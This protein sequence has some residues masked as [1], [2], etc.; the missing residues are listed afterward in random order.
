MRKIKLIAFLLILNGV[1]FAQDLPTA[2][3][4]FE[5]YVTAVGGKD[6]VGLIEDMTI[7]MTSS[8]SRGFAETEMIHKLPE[9]KGAMSVYANGREMMSMKYDGE[10]FNRASPWGGG[11]KPLEG[12]EAQMAGLQMHPFAEMLYLESGYEAVVDGI[13]QVNEKDAYKVTLKKGSKSFSNFYDVASG[14]KVK[15]IS[16]NSSPQGDFESTAMYESYEKFKGSEVLF[17]K[18]TKQV[19]AGGRGAMETSSEISGIKFNK[20]VKDKVFSID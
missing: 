18:I 10:R 12:E 20:G 2:S 7:S 16:K 9:Y 4:I 14:L 8:S 3:Q 6:A 1:A 19:T 11:N 15:S 5:N 17:P 13:E